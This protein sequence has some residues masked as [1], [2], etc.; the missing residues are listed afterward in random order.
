[1]SEPWTCR[2]MRRVAVP[3]WRVAVPGWRGNPL[4]GVRELARPIPESALR[5]L[6][7]RAAHRYPGLHDMG[8][9]PA[10]KVA[11]LCAAPC[12]GGRTA[13]SASGALACNCFACM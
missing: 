13:H 8:L 5:R 12:T 6:G 3:W 10:K 1:M 4:L 11:V 7:E 9:L 2:G